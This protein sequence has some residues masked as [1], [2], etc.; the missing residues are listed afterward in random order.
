MEYLNN[1]Q[2]PQQNV[3]ANEPV[4]VPVRKKKHILLSIW[5]AIYPLLVF[6]LLQFIIA[7]LFAIGVAIV[8][9][10]QI[11]S[12]GGSV[13]DVMKQI[14]VTMTTNGILVLLPTLIVDLI[15]IRLASFL[16]SLD[17][18]RYPRTK[19]RQIRVIDYLLAILLGVFANFLISA[20]LTG[21]RLDQYFPDYTDLMKNIVMAPM[22]LQLITVGIVAPIAEE[23]L[24]RALVLGRLRRFM[25]VWAAVL[26]QAVLFGVIHMNVL[27]GIYAAILGILL[28]I[29]Y[30]KHNS[31]TTCITMHIVINS[32]STLLPAE[33]GA[34]WN[35][36]AIGIISAVVVFG[37]LFILV[38]QKK[39]FVVQN[40]GTE[41][42]AVVRVDDGLI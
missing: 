40:E 37:V 26:V 11:L 5:G 19:V 17:I 33:L 24:M 12:S 3:P 27:Q 4:S 42:A 30:V 10:I 20:V 13:S 41:E 36:A 7:I 34:D 14:E 9:A 38:K 29:L 28:G 25:P 16:D 35:P 21:F 39:R 18:E 31:L 22:W 6:I 32:M 15:V 2:I 1:T 23:Y 8:T